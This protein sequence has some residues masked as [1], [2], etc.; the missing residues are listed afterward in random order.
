MPPSASL[1]I[2]NIKYLIKK[3]NYSKVFIVTE[4]QKYIEILKNEFKEKCIYFPSFRMQN[5]DSFK[6]YPRKNH[7]YLL[8]KEILIETLLLSECSGLTCVKSNVAS[9]AIVLAKKKLKL[10]EMFLG[11]NSRN[12]YIARW[13][14]YLK[15]NLPLLLGKIKPEKKIRFK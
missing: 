8:G 1:M 14:W 10:H 13:K 7:R 4:E 6:I 5:E 9:A 2:K 15:V 3:F 11:Y 12:I